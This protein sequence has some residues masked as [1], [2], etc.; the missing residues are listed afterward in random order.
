MKEKKSNRGFTLVEILIVL[1]V[2][3]ILVSFAFVN[4]RIIRSNS[5]DNT[6]K[7]YLADAKLHAALY[8]DSV[9][10]F[11]ADTQPFCTVANG[12]GAY[13]LKAAQQLG[14]ATTVTNG[15]FTYSTTGG[16]NSAVCHGAI[17]SAKEEWA[18]IV[19]LKNPV[20]PGAGWCVDSSGNSKE[21]TFLESYPSGPVDGRI[22]CP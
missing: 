9:P 1:A 4:F 18:A 10:V 12:P 7:A 3:T 16:A 21:S 17:V 15:T 6:I 5:A 8:K 22:L 19:S 11:G 13:I 20:T 14:A 2:L